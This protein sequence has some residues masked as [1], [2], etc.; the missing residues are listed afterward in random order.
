MKNKEFDQHIRQQ[1]DS[2]QPEQGISSWDSFES[3]L[4]SEL[5]TEVFDQQIKEKVENFQQPF[6]ES[7]WNLFLNQFAWVQV[8]TRDLIYNKAFEAVLFILALSFVL[9]KHTIT[10]EAFKIADTEVFAIEEDQYSYGNNKENRSDISFESNFDSKTLATDQFISQQSRNIS[11][12]SDFSTTTS[13]NLEYEL[14]GAQYSENRNADLLNSRLSHLAIDQYKGASV[15]I[16]IPQKEPSVNKLPLNDFQKLTSEDPSFD[17]NSPFAV[18]KTSLNNSRTIVSVFTSMDI[19]TIHTPYDAIYLRNGYEQSKF[20]IGGGFSIG[21]N[22]NRWTL[23]TGLLFSMKQYNPKTVLEIFRFN[24]NSESAEAISLRAIELNTLSIPLHLRFELFQGRKFTPYLLAGMGLNLATHANYDREQFKIA[25][26]QPLPSD[27]QVNPGNTPRLDEKRFSD[28]IIQGGSFSEN[29]F[30]SFNS[31]LGMDYQIG[32]Q[33]RLFVEM[34]YHYNFME[35]ELGPNNDRINTY[36][37]KI[38][39]RH[40]LQK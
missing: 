31:G 10:Y 18:S 6:Q 16:S 8:F 13:T 22:K 19:N 1:L 12:I 32:P 4:D 14:N 36:S 37:F 28:G 29:Y 30:L 35:K 25:L 26:A 2:I 23:E 33:W 5:G 39:G 38:G 27:A 21:W 15:Y 40:V 3:L 11:N 34:S 7:H 17:L 20:G 9:P 24:P